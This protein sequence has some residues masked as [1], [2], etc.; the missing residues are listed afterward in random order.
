MTPDQLAHLNLAPRA[1]AGAR[2][3][4][5]QF[6]QLV[7]TSGRRNLESQAHAMATH[8]VDDPLWIDKTYRRGHPLQLAVDRYRL[9]ATRWDVNGLTDA[10]WLA[11]R[12]MPSAEQMGISRHLSG[13]A[14][15][16]A[17]DAACG[18]DAAASAMRLPGVEEVLTNEGGFH[19]LHVQFY[20]EETTEI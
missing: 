1:E 7:F 17:W 9:T 14:F 18:P 10:L 5:I 13:H 3:L 15:D 12:A 4:S 6:P 20:P 11:L 2:S 16:C 8:V 19:I